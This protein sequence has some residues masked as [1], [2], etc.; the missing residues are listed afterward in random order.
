MI[1]FGLTVTLVTKGAAT[2]VDPLGNK[3]YTPTSRSVK[4][5]V[6]APGGSV[7]TLG[8]QDTVVTQPTLYMPAGTMPDPIDQVTVPGF[9][10]FE[11]D[12]QPQIWPKNPFTGWQPSNPVVVRLLQVSG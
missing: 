8:G 1:P 12:G 4:G 5:C 6:Y 2:G 3:T 10:T 7:E 11:V 9:G